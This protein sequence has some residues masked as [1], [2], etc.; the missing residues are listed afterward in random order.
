MSKIEQIGMKW[1]G[2][3]GAI[4]MDDDAGL[5]GTQA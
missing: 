5:P 1:F 2:I 3:N 4:L